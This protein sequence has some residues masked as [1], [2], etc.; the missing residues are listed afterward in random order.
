MSNI[1]IKEALTSFGLSEKETKIYLGTLE[2][3][4]ASANE[5][6]KKS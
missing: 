4:T 5:I 6:S 1:T 3:G 2:L